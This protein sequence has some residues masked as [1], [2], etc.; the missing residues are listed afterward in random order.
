MFIVSSTSLMGQVDPA[1]QPGQISRYAWSNFGLDS[2][3]DLLRTAQWSVTPSRSDELAFPDIPEN[4]GN[5][6]SQV[7]RGYLRAPVTG[8]YE[9]WLSANERSRL[10]IGTSSDKFSALKR[11]SFENLQWFN[12]DEFGAQREQASMPIVLEAGQRYYFELHHQEL[13]GPDFI[14]LAWSYCGGGQLTNWALEPSAVAS[15]SSTG[16]GGIAQRAIDGNTN[17]SWSSGTITHTWYQ[18]NPSWKVDLGSDR[19]IDRIEIFNRSNDGAFIAARLSNY[20]VSVLDS[21]GQTVSSVDFHTNGSSTKFAELWDTLGIIGRTVKV[22][23]LGAGQLALAEV[24]VFGRDDQAVAPNLDDVP[25]STLQNWSLDPK[26]L[27]TQSSTAF[28][29]SAERAIDN[30]T[31]GFYMSESITHTS[32]EVG[33]FWEVDLG[34][35]RQIDRIEIFN[36]NLDWPISVIAARLSNFRVSVME[37]DRTVVISTDR[38]TSG[39][40]TRAAEFWETGGV[41]G[42]IIRVEKLGMGASSLALSEVRVLGRPDPAALDAIYQPMTLVPADAFESF[43]GSGRDVDSDELSDVWEVAHGFDPAVSQAGGFAAVAD[44]D[45]DGFS[46]FDESRYAADPFVKSSIEGH[47]MIERWDDLDGYHVSDLFTSDAFYQSPSV[48]EPI[49]NPDYR[50]IPAFSGTRIRGYLTAPVS[51]DYYFWLSARDGA[52][53]WLS[54]DAT[55]YRKRRLVE[56]GHEAGSGHGVNANDA[57]RFD[58][59]ACQ[60]SEAVQLVAGERYFYEI[61]GKRGHP[62]NPQYQAAWFI[63]GDSERTEIP[64][65]VF[66]SYSGEAADGDDDY[67]P[68]SWESQFGLDTSDNG[69]LGRLTEGERGDFDQDG[70]S[71]REEFVLGT[72]PSSVDTDNDGLSDADEMNLYR[73]DPLVSDAAPEVLVASIDPLTVDGLGSTWTSTPSGGVTGETFRGTGSWSFTVPSDGYWIIEVEGN[74]LGSVLSREKV[75]FK[76]GVDG[77]FVQRADMVFRNGL[78][79]KLRILTPFLTTGPHELDLLID[80]YVG[81]RSV[82]VVSLQLLAPG[83]VDT[84][85]DGVPN[86]VEQALVA[87]SFVNSHGT[88][89]HISP[90]FIEGKTSAMNLVDLTV[91]TRSGQ[92]DRPHRFNDGQWQNMLPGFENRLASYQT[93]L[94]RQLRRG[95]GRMEGTSFGYQPGPGEHSW[96]SYLDLARNEAVGYVAI[97]EGLGI[98]EHHS[99]VWTP[100]NV[101][102]GGQI[103]IPAGSELLLGA[104]V[105]D[106]DWQTVTLTVDGV[107]HSFPAGESHVHLFDTAGFYQVNAS[108]PNGD[109]GDLTVVVKDASFTEDLVLLEGVV[110]EVVLPEIESD[111]TLSGGDLVRFRESSARQ[112]G[113]SAVLASSRV[114]GVHRVAARLEPEGAILDIGWAR[115]SGFSDVLRN[116]SQSITSSENPDTRLIS[117]RLLITDFPAGG[118]VDVVIFRAGVTF[119]DGTTF[120]RLTSEDFANN[121]HLLQFLMPRGLQGGYCHSIRIFNSDGEMLTAG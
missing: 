119:L 68:D 80:N 6:Y 118:W 13:T 89:S 42:Q 44:P 43:A 8:N 116:G 17:G 84:N 110:R 28:E 67:L 21:V 56:M 48:F 74:L 7:F 108:H 30:N 38:H 27:A 33:A 4:W 65:G 47:L 50:D 87:R 62:A 1:G 79:G 14:K 66:S 19:L 91:I 11:I 93:N 41:Q 105:Q 117:S 103:E 55:K 40:H 26:A 39:T 70:L 75:S 120:L 100:Y 107:S 29:G 86:T 76:I 60:M 99:V 59:Y 101:L 2:S 88:F 20:R 111:V 121:Q 92:V 113:G 15:Q 85:G 5:N 109:S 37:A 58:H 102:D 115:V 95:H 31:S 72:N 61:I 18:Q 104:W 12:S 45:G 77:E 3:I 36:R 83:G 96:Y 90:F 94:L 71:N 98:A 49:T 25:C 52:E 16:F 78:A 35:Q 69:L 51:G 57:N 97:F 24:K 32:N 64:M 54:P 82:E 106:W 112:E 63:P 22:E 73:T 114:P 81:R 23:L 34:S 10:F 46:N 53:L 9:F